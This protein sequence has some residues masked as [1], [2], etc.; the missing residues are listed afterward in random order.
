MLFSFGR[1]FSVREQEGAIDI[2]VVNPP[3]ERTVAVDVAVVE[4]IVV[5]AVVDKE[6]DDDVAWQWLTEVAG[7]EQH[8]VED[9]L[10]A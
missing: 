5:V 8:D 6:E 10:G 3:W 1:W 7:E 9:R 4:V 2:A